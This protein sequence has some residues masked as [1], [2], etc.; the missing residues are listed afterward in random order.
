MNIVCAAAHAAAAVAACNCIVNARMR[1]IRSVM[2]MRRD[3]YHICAFMF[4][5][6]AVVLYCA[7]ELV[8]LSTHPHKRLISHLT[9]AR[10]FLECRRLMD[11]RMVGKIITMF[12]GVFVPICTGIPHNISRVY[13]VFIA[14]VGRTSYW[15]YKFMFVALK[16]VALDREIEK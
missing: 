4:C 14:I 16:W 15:R 2:L 5:L 11:V 9:R 1:V 7:P 12:C 3:P 8:N 10:G 13:N 6:R